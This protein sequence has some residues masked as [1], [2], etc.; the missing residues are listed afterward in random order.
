MYEIG[1]LV[2]VLLGTRIP[3]WYDDGKF[4]VAENEESKKMFNAQYSIAMFN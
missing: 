3:A 2:A 4:V 1:A